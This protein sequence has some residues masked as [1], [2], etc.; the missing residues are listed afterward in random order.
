MAFLIQLLKTM[1]TP[2]ACVDPDVE[3]D[4]AVEHY[5]L[6][7]QGMAPCYVCGEWYPEQVA[8]YDQYNRLVQVVDGKQWHEQG[9]GG[10]LRHPV[11]E[12][13]VRKWLEQ[14]VVVCAVYVQEEEEEIKEMEAPPPARPSSYMIP[15][16]IL[17]PSCRSPGFRIKDKKP[18]RQVEDTTP[19]A[20]PRS[21]FQFTFTSE[22]FRTAVQEAAQEQLPQQQQKQTMTMTKQESGAQ[23]EAEGDT[24]E[25]HKT[26][27]QQ[28]L[29]QES[30]ESTT[31]PSTSIVTDEPSIIS[32]A[33]KFRA[34]IRVFKTNILTPKE[35]HLE[36]SWG[37]RRVLVNCSKDLA[38][39]A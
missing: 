1:Q 14:V 8:L 18:S 5:H 34:F 37:R 17:D 30:P 33:D 29:A 9:Q 16:E 4:E 13:Q 2:E 24:E 35:T 22:R 20:S 32:D 6:Q 26:E 7:Q 25:F 19:S 28:Q 3:Y 39:R 38:T 11:A 12:R 36:A 27:Q 31:S 21:S 10:S 15:Q 23:Q